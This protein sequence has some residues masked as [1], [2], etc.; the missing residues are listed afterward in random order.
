MLYDCVL[1]IQYSTN[2][3]F[4]A[5]SKQFPKI[6]INYWCNTK[7]DILIITGNHL[8][9]GNLIEKLNN[10]FS[11]IDQLSSDNLDNTMVIK[12]CQCA[13]YPMDMVL[14]ELGSLDIPPIRFHKGREYHRIMIDHSSSDAFIEKIKAHPSVSK[15][16]IQKLAPAKIENHLY[17]VYISLEDIVSKIS[18]KQFEALTNAYK[19]GYYEIPRKITAEKLANEMNIHRRTYEEHLRKAEN[20]IMDYIVPVLRMMYNKI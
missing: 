16:K 3:P 19:S 11:D 8:N 12:S 17:P 20:S 15:I 6:E 13:S 7:I 4:I 10:Y 9:T 5:F 18:K 1:E 2:T 14:E